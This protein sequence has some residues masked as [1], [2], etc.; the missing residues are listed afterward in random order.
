MSDPK[1]KT[2]E[3]RVAELEAFAALIRSRLH[4]HL[5]LPSEDEAKARKE[6]AHG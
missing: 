2:I 5:G 6:K 3:E 1:A 4:E